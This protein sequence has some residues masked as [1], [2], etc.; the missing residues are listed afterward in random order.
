MVEDH[1]VD[2]L[3][4]HLDIFIVN[5]FFT[6]DGLGGGIGIE[7][8]DRVGGEG[9]GLLDHGGH[10]EAAG[11]ELFKKTVELLVGHG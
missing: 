10:V 9:D 7:A 4:F 5:A 11:L 3:A 1:Q 2:G 6:G 8:D